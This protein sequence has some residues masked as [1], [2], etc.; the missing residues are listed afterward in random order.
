M[1]TRWIFR[2]LRELFFCFC[3]VL[4]LLG[5]LDLSRADASA[6]EPERRR[7][8]SE[9]IVIS[10]QDES[11]K[12]FLLSLM[13]CRKEDSKSSTFLHYRFA[14]LIYDTVNFDL[15]DSFS[16]VH[17]EEVP[18]GFLE[19]FRL[20]GAEDLS[21][22][23]S[24]SLTVSIGGKTMKIEIPE[25]QGEFLIKNTPD[26][27]K[28]SS[29]SPASVQIDGKTLNFRA[30]VERIYSSDYSTYVFFP[31]HG[32]TRSETH[33]FVLWDELG[34]L[35]VLDT[36]QVGEDN[37]SYRSHTW[38]LSKNR[39]LGVLR[40]AFEAHV[41]FRDDPSGGEWNISVPPLEVKKL[42]LKILVP[43]K[44]RADEGMV[45]G[46]IEIGGERHSVSG[47]YAHHSYH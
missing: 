43:K 37:P 16:D 13:F 14:S 26:Y 7:F 5:E 33:S 17:A 32:K 39:K 1:A 12:D 27:T 2:L 15:T 18:H 46:E 35:L 38:V 45:K 10:G 40:K 42:H 41:A 9:D 20:R 44:G 3:G 23:E 47:Y 36:S 30:Y 24:Y 34:N 31:G 28:Y 6:G 11:G 21:T 8:F 4:L 19:S 29:D 25:L 22:R